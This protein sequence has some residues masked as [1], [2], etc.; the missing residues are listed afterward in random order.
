MFDP[1]CPACA[2]TTGGC[3]AHGLTTIVIKTVPWPIQLMT[4]PTGWKCPCCLHVW[5]P[6]VTECQRCAPP[7]FT[8][9]YGETTMGYGTTTVP[10]ES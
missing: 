1:S 10:I 2:Q 7:N 9:T 3:P 5:A 4:V 8:V 6:H